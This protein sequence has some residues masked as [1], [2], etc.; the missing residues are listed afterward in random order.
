[1]NFWK[2]KISRGGNALFSCVPFFP[3]GTSH[4][5]EYQRTG[6]TLMWCTSGL[7]LQ[8]GLIS[9]L[10]RLFWHWPQEVSPVLW[11]RVGKGLKTRCLSFSVRIVPSSGDAACTSSRSGVANWCVTCSQHPLSL[12][13]GSDANL[14][15]AEWVCKDTEPWLPT[16][17]IQFEA[18]LLCDCS[19]FTSPLRKRGVFQKATCQNGWEEELSE[20]PC[21]CVSRRDPFFPPGCPRAGCVSGLCSCLPFPTA[22]TGLQLRGGGNQRSH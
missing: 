21:W 18:A 2:G 14:D 7:S 4:L 15:A 12:P 20:H 5:N 6:V 19:E 3:I 17:M 22:G 11:P 9:V 1:M 10:R 8:F 13:S 16:S